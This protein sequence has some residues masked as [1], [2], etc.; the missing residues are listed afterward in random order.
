[1]S[2]VLLF[3]YLGTV[4]LRSLWIVLG[5][6]YLTAGSVLAMSRHHYPL[7]VWSTFYMAGLA[8]LLFF[9]I[10]Y[11]EV[12]EAVVTLSEFVLWAVL[13]LGGTTA[14]IILLI[15]GDDL[16]NSTFPKFYQF[17][18][19]L[20]DWALGRDAVLESGPEDGDDTQ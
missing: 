19:F 4:S 14:F 15:V 20:I 11:Y 10:E 2:D 7:R 9:N 5:I 16:D 3:P 6:W 18:K 17:P 1:M 13:L 12:A 8:I